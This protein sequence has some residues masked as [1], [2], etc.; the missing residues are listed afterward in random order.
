MSAGPAVVAKGSAA[1]YTHLLHSKPWYRNTRLIILNFWIGIMQVPEHIL[2]Y[3]PLT[4][5]NRFLSS[6]TYGYDASMMNG[7]QSLTQWNQAFDY[8]NGANLGLLSAIQNIGALCGY[9]FAPYMSDGMGRRFSV[10]FGASLMIVATAMQTASMSVEMFIGARFLVGFGQ[11]FAAT[12]APLLVAEV[13]YPSHRAKATSLYNSLGFVG[14]H[15]LP[16]RSA[17]WSTYG[18][19]TIQ[20]SWSWR[21]PSALQAVSSL[22]QVLLFWFIPESPRWLVSKGKEER[23]LEVLSYYHADGNAQDPLVQYEFEEIKAAIAFDREVAGNV[24]WLSL[25]KTPGNRKRVRIV[26][27]LAVFSQWSGNGLVNFYLNKVFIAIGI[28]DQLTQLLFGGILTTYNFV[29]SV[30]AGIYC[31]RVG[32]RPLFLTSCA[33]MTVFWIA[34]TICFSIHQNTGSTSAGYAFVAFI[35]FRAQFFSTRLIAFPPL[36]ISYSV[37]IFPFDLRA[38]GYIVFSFALSLSLI[39]NQYVNPIAL[40]VLQWKY[41][42]VYIFWL[43]FEFGFCY[44]YI[45]ETRHR[46]L[47]ETAAMFDG[48]EG[49][50]K[51]HNQAAAYAGITHG[52]D[53]LK[54]KETKPD[55]VVATENEAS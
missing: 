42:L 21:I 48:Q 12:A 1:A 46:T 16:S 40:Q 34:Q 55:P 45:I 41:Y 8:P 11:T 22:I 23:A 47:E 20:S 52:V 44:F 30:I 9:P 4:G 13:A 51:I 19:F 36:L 43:C 38:K 33:G 6:Y 3:I 24:G 32:R 54:E 10:I 50:T 14:T 5:P 37:E 25:F 18:T 2:I 15:Q 49:V 7:L 28:T 35:C 27:A 17:A 53:E 26:V 31:D 29:V 39:F